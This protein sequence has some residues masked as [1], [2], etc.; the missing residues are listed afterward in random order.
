MEEEERKARLEEKKLL[1]AEKREIDRFEREMRLLERKSKVEQLDSSSSSGSG[2]RLPHAPHF[3][4]TVFNEK[5]DQLDTFFQH[6]EM[7]CTVL[8]VKEKERAAYLISLFRVRLGK[9]F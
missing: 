2:N 5:T 6:F 4:F 3:K 1:E 8:G 9:L 7:Q